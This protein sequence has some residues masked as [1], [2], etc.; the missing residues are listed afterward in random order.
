LQQK[1]GLIMEKVTCET[2]TPGKN[3][4]KIARWKYDLLADAILKVLPKAKPGLAFQ[5]LPAMVGEILGEDRTKIGSLTWYITTVKLDL[6]AKGKLQKVTG[7][8]PQYL[9][10]N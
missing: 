5:E 10:K 4:I 8:K 7:V 6:E 3:P 2:P 1:I 9:I